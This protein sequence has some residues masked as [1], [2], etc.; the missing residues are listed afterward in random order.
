MVVPYGSQLLH[1]LVSLSLSL[2]NC[3]LTVDPIEELVVSFEHITYPKLPFEEKKEEEK[4]NEEEEEET[5][6]CKMEI[7]S[8]GFTVID[9]PTPVDSLSLTKVEGNFLLIYMYYLLHL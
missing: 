6:E 5:E 4:S 2:C 7:I 3:H 9:P 8:E 1:S